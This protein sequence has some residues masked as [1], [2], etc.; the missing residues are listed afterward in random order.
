[1]TRAIVER[2]GR[3]WIPADAA[4]AHE[5]ALRVLLVPHGRRE[6][7]SLAAGRVR[8]DEAVEIEL[9]PSGAPLDARFA[10]VAAALATIAEKGAPPR[11]ILIEDYEGGRGR[12]LV[13]LLDGGSPFAVVKVR[14][15]GEGR[16]LRRERDALEQIGAGGMRETVP[17][18]RAFREE[19]GGEILALTAVRGVSMYRQMKASLRPSRHVGSHFEGAAAWL[20]RFQLSNPGAHGDYWAR[21]V[22]ADRDAVS[23]VDWE[24]YEREGDPGSDV[25]HFPLTYALAYRWDAA[26]RMTAAERFRRGFIERS[27]VAIA[28]AG[29][30]RRFAASRGVAIE[31]LRRALSV[32]LERGA[33]GQVERPALDAAEWSAMRD[34]LRGGTACAFS[35]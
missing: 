26:D 11:W 21:N 33:A 5:Y 32:H 14:A 19:G 27:A 8:R 18:V 34:L 29:W 28:A 15:A 12:S 35:G 6:R 4:G 13:V 7:L 1:M 10:P 2:F 17:A 25:I 23:V 20:E 22:L 3:V 9:A 30:M 31:D 16:T 24:H